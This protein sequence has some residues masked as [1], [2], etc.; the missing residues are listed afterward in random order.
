MTNDEV[1]NI[2]RL[3][4]KKLKDAIT[5]KDL[6]AFATQIEKKVKD[7]VH[8]AEERIGKKVKDEARWSEQRIEES[9]ESKIEAPFLKYRNEIMTKLDNIAGM[10]Q[11]QDEEYTIHQGQHDEISERLDKLER[12][13]SPS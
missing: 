2:S 11:K 9:I 8:L 10:L 6:S 3:L 13:T 7:E 4:D 5:K 12:T 1:Q